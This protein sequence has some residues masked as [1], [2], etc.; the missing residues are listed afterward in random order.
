MD[1]AGPEIHNTDSLASRLQLKS[2]HH[3]GDTTKEWMKRLS[4]K[5]LELLREYQ[6]GTEMKIDL[7]IDQTGLPGPLLVYVSTIAVELRGNY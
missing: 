2:T 3:A 5:E 6:A 7:E 1:P 4:S